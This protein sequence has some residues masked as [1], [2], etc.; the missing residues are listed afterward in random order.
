MANLIN[1]IKTTVNLFLDIRK[2]RKDGSEIVLEKKRVF[3]II[4]TGGF[5]NTVEGCT[6]SW[7]KEICDV[8]EAAFDELPDEVKYELQFAPK[9]GEFKDRV[10]LWRAILKP[11][12]TDIQYYTAIK[13][14]IDWYIHIIKI[15]KT[16]DGSII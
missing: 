1:D 8:A 4:Q 14:I 2:S 6:L 12:M 5:Y 11:V 16:E 10:N 15:R 9:S 3:P 13:A 7:Y